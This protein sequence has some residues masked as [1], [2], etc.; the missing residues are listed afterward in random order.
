MKLPSNGHLAGVLLG[1]IISLSAQAKVPAEQANRLSTDLTPFGAIRAGDPGL[2]ISEWTGG[3]RKAPSGYEGAGHFEVDPYPNQR[4][5]L[6]IDAKNQKAYAEHLSEGVRAMFAAYPETFRLP[7]YPTER[8]F[9][10]P[11]EIYTN[12]VRNAL[13][14]DLN[15]GGNGMIHAYGGIPFPIPQSGLEAIWNHIARWQGRYFEETSTSA[16]VRSDGSVSSLREENQLLFNYYDLS[17]NAD[18]LENILFFY[19]NQV[20][21][22][23][24]SAGE[25]L[26]VHETIDQTVEPRLAWNYFPGQRR[27]RRAPTVAYDNPV[28]GYVSDDADMFNGAPNRFDWTLVGRRALYVPYN[29]YRLGKPGTPHEQ[30]LQKGHI[31]PDLTRWEMHRVWVVEA[32]L[33]SGERHVYAKRRFYLD[34]DSWGILMA[35][36]YDS[37]GQLWRVNFAYTKQAY[38]VPTLTTEMIVYHDL[39]KREY[40]ALGLRSL[41]KAP[42]V[43][44]VTPP[45]DSYWQPANLRRMGVN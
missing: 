37:H 29:N 45:P 9:A 28:D 30:I 6:V 23:S 18:N 10:A 34:E 8:S 36:S 40:S 39:I 7:V 26:L 13:N 33:K 31:N 17:K 2:G 15:P 25:L 35:E 21:P 32:T 20:L 3:L 42:R 1:A 43:F 4:A 27:V 38:E 5:V 24:R 41:E 19:M 11:D 16:S 22:P 12:T 44:N 14:A